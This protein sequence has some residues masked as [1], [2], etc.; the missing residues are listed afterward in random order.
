MTDGSASRK[1][2]PRGP[3]RSSAETRQR[4]ID[5]ALA[6][7][8]SNGF[9]ATSTRDI[10]ARTG[11]A[12]PAIAYHFGGKEGLYRACAE[13]VVEQYRERMRAD[14][15][16]SDL[17]MPTTPAAARGALRRVMAILAAMLLDTTG[18]EGWLTF[19]IREMNGT[20]LAHELLYRDLWEPGLSLVA[21]LVAATRGR[22]AAEEQDKLEALLLLSSFSAFSASRRVALDFGGWPSIDERLVT[23]MLARLDERIDAL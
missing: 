12:L 3:Y 6:L 7:F 22:G 13:H 19:M 21:A 17:T 11:V 1:S 5:A 2:S 18:N 15:I 4:L 9:E 20:G 14:A 8:G 23:A 16:K 10:A